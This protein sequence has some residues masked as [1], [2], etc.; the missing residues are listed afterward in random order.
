MQTRGLYASR[1]MI[2]VRIPLGPCLAHAGVLPLARELVGRGTAVILAANSLPSINDITAPELQGVLSQAGSMDRSLDRALAEGSLVAVPSGSDLPV[3]D[4][5][6]ASLGAHAHW[7]PYSKLCHKRGSVQDM[8]GQRG[9][10]A[11]RCPRR[12]GHQRGMP[13]W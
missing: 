12:S 11:S 10:A 7:R 9:G 2:D 1:A 5:R 13:I 6:Q 3:I 4:L 8:R